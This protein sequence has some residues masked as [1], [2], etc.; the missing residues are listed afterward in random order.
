MG[1]PWPSNAICRRSGGCFRRT[2]R[3]GIAE[4]PPAEARSFTPNAIIREL[5]TTTTTRAEDPMR[6]AKTGIECSHAPTHPV[7]PRYVPST[8][9]PNPSV[10]KSQ[11]PPRDV[12]AYSHRLIG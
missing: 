11:L 2:T 4:A 9:G 12:L 1:E 8:L 7:R 10:Y 3:N 6:A 5:A